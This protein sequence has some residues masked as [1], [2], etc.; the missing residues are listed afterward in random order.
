MTAHSFTQ[1]VSTEPSSTEYIR[2]F[3]VVKPCTLL[4]VSSTIA[5]GTKANSSSG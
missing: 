3:F 5:S 2:F 4:C 1:L